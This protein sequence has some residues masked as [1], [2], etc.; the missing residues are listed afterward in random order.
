MNTC[1]LMPKELSLMLLP[2]IGRSILDME[3]TLWAKQHLHPGREFRADYGEAILDRLEVYSSLHP[4]DVR[5]VYHHLL[6][7]LQ[8]V[9]FYFVLDK[10]LIFLNVN[11]L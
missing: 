8:F 6:L 4:N 1:I 11:I 9:W 10:I 2:T 5:F 7:I 3:V